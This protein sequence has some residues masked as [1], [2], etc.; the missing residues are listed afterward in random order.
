MPYKGSVMTYARLYLAKLL[1]ECDFV[2]YSD[3]DFLW[4]AD[5]KKLWDMKDEK[6]FVQSTIDECASVKGW[7]PEDEWA[8]RNGFV[9]DR[10]H[11]FC[12]GLCLFNLAKLR[13]GMLDRLFQT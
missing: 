1:P 9:I 4:L 5:V 6:F 3:V 7:K 11:Y 10:K 2:L 8:E 13:E 12:A